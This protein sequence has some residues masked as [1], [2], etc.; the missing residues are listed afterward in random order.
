VDAVSL[1][2]SALAI[3]SILAVTGLLGPLRSSSVPADWARS[4]LVAGVGGAIVAFAW[5]LQ[6]L[7]LPLLLVGPVAALGALFASLATS[8]L[9][10]ESTPRR[11]LLAAVATTLVFVPAVRPVFGTVFDPFGTKLGVIDLGGALPALIAS[12]AFALG[13]VLFRRRSARADPLQGRGWGILV[14]AILAWAAAVGWLVGVELASDD[15]VPVILTSALVIPAFAAAA[16]SV[17]ERLRFRRTT[18]QGIVTGLLAGIAAA[19]PAGAFVTPPLAVVIGLV[20]G[21]IGAL[22]PERLRSWPATTLAVGA[23]VSTVLVGVL[24]TNIGY[25]YTG[26]PELVFGQLFITVV[27]VAGGG[28]VGI[29]AGWLFR[30]WRLPQ[31]SA[32]PV[33]RV[34]P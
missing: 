15:M 19:V 31:R 32:A 17:V 2:F 8:L 10:S 28:A 1:G 33:D 6:L 18:A 3:V 11:L 27:V 22:L 7:V 13:T 34:R 26:Q 20:V 14:P 23:S 12:G 9:D 24:G 5:A 29:A 16:G 25:I 30:R 4:V 21:V